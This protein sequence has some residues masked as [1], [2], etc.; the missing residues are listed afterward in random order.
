MQVAQNLGSLRFSEMKLASHL[1][2]WGPG[3]LGSAPGM[4]LERLITCAPSLRR[5]AGESWSEPKKRMDQE[6][7]IEPSNENHAF[8]K[9][10]RTTHID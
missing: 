3:V 4:W 7:M 6:T 2:P 10:E 8:E 1:G 5:A 9:G